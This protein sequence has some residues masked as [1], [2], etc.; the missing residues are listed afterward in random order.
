MGLTLNSNPGGYA[1]EGPMAAAA[2]RMAPPLD[3][4]YSVADRPIGDAMPAQFDTAAAPTDILAKL[5][6]FGG[7]DKGKDALSAIVGS[8]GGGQ[9]QQAPQ[10]QS[11]RLLAQSAQEDAARMGAAQQLMAQLM[12]GK[13][14]KILGTSLMG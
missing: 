1:S 7:S 9:K 6:S 13:K 12:A 4:P 3:A 2:S 14:K 11:G 5:K 10:I 8:F